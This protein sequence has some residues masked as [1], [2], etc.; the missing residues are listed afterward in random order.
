MMGTISTHRPTLLIELHGRGPAAR[1]LSK[2]D[3]HRYEY[4]IPGQHGVFLSG[5][6]LLAWMPEACVQVI[7]RP[8]SPRQRPAGLVR[9]S[10]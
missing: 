3:L 10:G 9:E 2:V 4:R 8:L 5:A 1:T 6:E 7:A